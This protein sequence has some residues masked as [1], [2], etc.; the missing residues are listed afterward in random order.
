MFELLRTNK[1]ET[2]RPE[3]NISFGWTLKLVKP[4]WLLFGPGYTGVG[5]YAVD[6]QKENST[7]D[8]LSLKIKHAVSPEAGLLCKLNLSKKIGLALRYTFQYRF[9]LDKADIDYIGKTRHVFGV[10]FCF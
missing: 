8:D 2:V 9:A 5:K 7:E 3:L 4:V 6:E 1:N 10:G